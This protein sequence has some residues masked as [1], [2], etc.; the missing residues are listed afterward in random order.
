MTADKKINV[1]ILAAV[2]GGGAVLALGWLGATSGGPG[3]SL[4]VHL[5][6][7]PPTVASPIM[8]LGATTTTEAPAT[9]EP[10]AKA[11]PAIKGPAALPSEEAGLP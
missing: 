9:E 1:R 8:S 6:P 10:V 2:A 7:P 4:A 3:A 11:A 5:P